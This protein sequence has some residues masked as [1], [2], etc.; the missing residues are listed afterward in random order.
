M[1]K[2][3]VMSAEMYKFIVDN[4]NRLQYDL[5]NGLVITPKNTNGTVC[6]STGYLRVKVNGRTLQV[7]Q[8][9]AV[10]YFGDKCIGMQVNHKDGNKLNNKEDN[11]ELVTQIENIRHAWNDGLNENSKKNGFAKTLREK[12]INF[13]ISDEQVSEIRE[14]YAT[15]EYTQKRL[16]EMYGV[17][18]KLIWNFVH[19]KERYDR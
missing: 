3:N 2:R 8:I 14:L 4:E 18:R 13:K 6:K 5:D 17:S 19:K 11:L 9:L 7:H 10:K 15:G 12:H 16:A 1:S